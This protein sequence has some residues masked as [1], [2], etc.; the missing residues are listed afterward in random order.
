MCSDGCQTSQINCFLRNYVGPNASFWGLK[1][2]VECLRSR[3]T[4]CDPSV[5]GGLAIGLSRPVSVEKEW[6]TDPDHAEI[7]AALRLQT[8]VLTCQLGC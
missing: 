5:P 2:L 1:C 3:P 7:D 8:R 6:G 4:R